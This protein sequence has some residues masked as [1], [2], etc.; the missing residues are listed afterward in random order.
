MKKLIM[1]TAIC[2]IVS[3]L[4]PSCGSNIMLTKRHYNNGY[5]VSHTQKNKATQ[6]SQVE[7][8]KSAAATVDS[9][10]VVQNKTEQATTAKI[11]NEVAATNNMVVSADKPLNSSV[12]SGSK[13]TVK[14]TNKITES[15]VAEIK[16]IISG[17]EKADHASSQREGLSLFWIVILVLLIL[18]AFG[19]GPIGGLIHLLLL[20][21][22]ILLVLWLLRII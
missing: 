11:N 1:F 16:Q 22:L 13:Q 19:F 4:F 17:T 21:A 2:L 18:W 5:Y 3:I 20:V 14:Q 15:P 6:K 10:P 9:L 7:E 12:S 8:E